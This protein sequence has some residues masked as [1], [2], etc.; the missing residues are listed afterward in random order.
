MRE[1]ES[2][3][4]NN[5]DAVDEEEAMERLIGFIE[6]SS[7]RGTQLNLIVCWHRRMCE[8]SFINAIMDLVFMDG[9]VLIIA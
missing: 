6:D 1:Q 4:D 8:E 2:I 7:V 5:L 3:L 9:I